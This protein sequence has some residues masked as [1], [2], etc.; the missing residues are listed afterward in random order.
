MIKS[1]SI[2]FPVYN[3]SNR[4]KEC[5]N[6]INKFNIIKSIKNI[7]YIFVDDGSKENSFNLISQFIKKKKSTNKIKYKVIRNIKNEGKGSALIKGI[8]MASKDWML[9]VD[10]DISVS[11]FEFN[12]WIKSDYLKSNY[13][14]YFGSR[15]LKKS[16]VKS[17][18]HRKFIGLILILICKIFFNIKLHD[19]QC[20]FKLY[21]KEIGKKIF[22]KIIHKKFSHD[23]EIVLLAKK[24]KTEIIELPVKWIH[25][26]GSKIHLIKDSISIFISLLKMKIFK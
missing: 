19:T 1:L 10:T 3:E 17:K 16:S 22:K 13:K 26:S 4:L 5:F 25:K 9:T 11:L 2:I 7:E 21:K 24:F 12:K 8:K 23:I 6:D 18:Y 14:I 15:N 20:G